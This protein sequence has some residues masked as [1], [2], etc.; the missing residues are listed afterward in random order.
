VCVDSTVGTE[1]LEVPRWR[2]CG[3][4]DAD[5]P[6]GRPVIFEPENIVSMIAVVESLLKVLKGCEVGI[7]GL[8]GV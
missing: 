3:C 8:K 2:M 5:T 4:G 7:G 6:G 1:D